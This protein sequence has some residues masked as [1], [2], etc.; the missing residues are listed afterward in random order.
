[1]D[2]ITFQDAMALREF[3]RGDRYNGCDGYDGYQRYDHY[4]KQTGRWSLSAAVWVIAAIIVLMA[5]L[6]FVHRTGQDKADLAASIQGLYGKVNAIEPAVTA[7]GNNIYAINSVLSATTQAVGDFKTTA[8]EQLA[9][10]NGTVFV[11]R[12]GSS[13]CGSGCN[14]GSSRFVKT[15]NYSLCDS[16][17][18]AIETCG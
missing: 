8:S 6:W 9:A 5:I 10:L 15:D 3:A 7:Q 18:Q 11:P 1:M 2:N 14:N 4:D 13:R 16:N 12:C 17:L